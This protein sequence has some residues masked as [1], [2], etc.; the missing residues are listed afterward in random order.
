M[1]AIFLVSGCHA[2]SISA[3]LCI[4]QQLLSCP[5][6]EKLRARAR[7]Y[8]QLIAVGHDSSLLFSIDR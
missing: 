7:L 5:G 3:R 8:S 2:V 1:S 4:G 6:V